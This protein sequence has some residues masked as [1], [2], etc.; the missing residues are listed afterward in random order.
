MRVRVT[1]DVD[2]TVIEYVRDVPRRGL[3]A[4]QRT[5]AM[6]PGNVVSIEPL[7]M[8]DATD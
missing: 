2:G 8:A 1:R 7:G 5:E 4:F 6:E 3:V